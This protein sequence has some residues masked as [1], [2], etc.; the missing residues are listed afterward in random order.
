M[1]KKEWKGF[2]NWTE[3]FLFLTLILTLTMTNILLLVSFIPLSPIFLSFHFFYIYLFLFFIFIFYF[4]FLFLFFFKFKFIFD[5]FL[6]LFLPRLYWN[7]DNCLC[8]EIF[9]KI[10]NGNLF[11][12]FYSGLFL[13]PLYIPLLFLSNHTIFSPQR[14][15]TL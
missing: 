14:W 11:S 15:L 8:L 6:L 5:P 10:G 9:S 7:R 3:L 4:L 13:L 2:W 12:C 1:Q